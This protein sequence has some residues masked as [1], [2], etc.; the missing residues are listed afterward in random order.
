MDHPKDISPHRQSNTLCQDRRKS[1]PPSSYLQQKNSKMDT[2]ILNRK[3]S[4]KQRIWSSSGSAQK[5]ELDLDENFL[6]INEII[7]KQKKRQFFRIWKN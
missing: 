4:Q 2:P 5:G 7:L 3:T 1:D 6:E